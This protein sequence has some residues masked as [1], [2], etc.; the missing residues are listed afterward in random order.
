ML[1]RLGRWTFAIIAPLFLFGCILTPGKFVSGLTINADRTFTFTYKGEVIAVDPGDEISQGLKDASGEDKDSDVDAAP[2]SKEPESKEDTEKK[3]GVREATEV[4]RQAIADALT[5][6]A[7][8]K[9]AR[10]VG[11]GKFLIDYEVSGILN[12]TFLY[13]F[14]SDAEILFPFLTVELRQG[15]TVRVKAPGFAND[16]GKAGPTGM[17][18]KANDIASK[19]DGTFTLNTDAEII[20]QNE[21]SGAKQEG[22]RKIISWRA[23]PLTKDAPSATLRFSK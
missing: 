12:H 3:A 14:N 10:Y 20:S 15:G 9:S 7:G 21:E 17:G 11:D 16:S 2:D 6:E 23:T 4:K 22:S 13:P 18:L 19:L 5:K 8:Y 1:D